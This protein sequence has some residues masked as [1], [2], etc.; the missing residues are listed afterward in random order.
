MPAVFKIE[1][2]HGEFTWVVKR[3]EKH[4]MEL[5]RELRTYKTFMRIPLPSRR[6]A[7]TL[8]HTHTHIDLHS[9]TTR[10]C[11]QTLVHS[12]FSHIALT[13]NLFPI[14]TAFRPHLRSE[15]TPVLDKLFAK[16]NILY[17]ESP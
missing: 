17:F 3:K 16:C 7:P 8:T 15:F 5:H 10:T 1:L 14:E 11:K 2:K 9:Y 12:R 4:F 6:L 13:C